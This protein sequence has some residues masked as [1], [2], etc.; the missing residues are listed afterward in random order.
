MLSD[1]RV[2][3]RA[4]RDRR[5][6]GATR[7]TRK[8][9]WQRVTLA[10]IAAGSGAASLRAADVSWD[11]GSSNFVWDTSSLNWTGAAWNNAA[12]NGAIFGFPGVGAISVPGILSVTTPAIFGCTVAK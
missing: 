10:A 5:T 3:V 7:L 11:N 4:N 1:P 9:I 6:S 2:H 12:G 8:R